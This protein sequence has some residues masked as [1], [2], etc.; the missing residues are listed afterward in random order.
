MN[1]VAVLVLCST[2]HAVRYMQYAVCGALHAVNY[3][4]QCGTD[5]SVMADYVAL[6]HDSSVRLAVLRDRA[7]VSNIK[8]HT[9]RS[10]D[11][12]DLY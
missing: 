10:R 6:L 12:Q 2:L 8:C 5:A 3:T 7:S 9:A 4:I 1:A 11:V